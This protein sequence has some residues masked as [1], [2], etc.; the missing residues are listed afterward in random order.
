MC[1]PIYVAPVS[2]ISYIGRP[3]GHDRWNWKDCIQ[4]V[5]TWRPVRPSA[6]RLMICPGYCGHQ[7]WSCQTLAAA[8]IGDDG[9][10]VRS[11]W[12]L[13]I[14]CPKLNTYSFITIDSMTFWTRS[15]LRTDYTKRRKRWEQST[16]YIAVLCFTRGLHD[17]KADRKDTEDVASIS[18]HLVES[19]FYEKHDVRKSKLFKRSY[20]TDAKCSNQ[21]KDSYSLSTDYSST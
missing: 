18:C 9:L 15:V 16:V 4:L 14:A 10:V 11:W 3:C 19:S 21:E 12:N 2:V 5:F 6:Y 7:L 1:T 8:A 20:I 13:E 17:A